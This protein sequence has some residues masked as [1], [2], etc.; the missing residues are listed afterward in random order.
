VSRWFVDTFGNGDAKQALSNLYWGLW[1]GVMFLVPE[2]LAATHTVPMY[3]LSRTSWNDEVTYSWLRTLIAGFLLGLIVHIR[4]ATPL[5]KAEL[6][7]V[8]IALLAHLTWA[9]L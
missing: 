6:G 3:T 5:G 4:F 9:A 1:V 2:L 8:G 7:G